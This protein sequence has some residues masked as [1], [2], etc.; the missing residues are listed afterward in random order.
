MGNILQN[1]AGM[2][3]M[4][5]QIIASDFLI[6]A[7]AGVRNYAVALSETTTPEVREVLRRHL[8]IAISMHEKITMFMIKKGYYHVEDPQE[9]LRI[10]IKNADTVLNLEQ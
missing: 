7:K 3:D 8:D 4:T 2:T 6:A 9:Q 10:D 5:E 1:I